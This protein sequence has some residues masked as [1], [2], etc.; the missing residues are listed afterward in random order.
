MLAFRSRPPR[1]GRL[2]RCLK[3]VRPRSPTLELLHC[4]DEHS[5]RFGEKLRRLED[6]LEPGCNAERLDDDISSGQRAFRRGEPERI[7]GHFF[8]LRWSRRILRAERASAP[9]ECPASSAAFTAS[10]PIPLLAPMIRIVATAPY[11]RSESAWLPLFAIR[12]TRRKT[13]ERL[14]TRFQRGFAVVFVS[15]LRV[16]DPGTR[17]SWKCIIVSVMTVSPRFQGEPWTNKIIGQALPRRG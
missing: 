2:P 7:A 14:E 1:P 5:R 10:R 8:S 9:T 3:G 17:R 13:G 16:A 4:G 15:R 6:G 11:S 12:P